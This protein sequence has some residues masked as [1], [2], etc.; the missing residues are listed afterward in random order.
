MHGSSS[1][2]TCHCLSYHLSECQ[3]PS[4]A[5]DEVNKPSTPV[6]LGN[7]QHSRFNNGFFV[8]TVAI[9]NL[10]LFLYYSLFT[11]STWVARTIEE[12][13]GHVQDT[14]GFGCS[15]DQSCGVT[16]DST[17]TAS[18]HAMAAAAALDTA[19]AGAL[20]C[21]QAAAD[22]RRRDGEA[23]VRGRALQV[24]LGYYGR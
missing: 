22:Q 18:I 2:D 24:R 11:K 9:D 1:D 20:D 21:R 16:F 12:G 13:S 8:I 17:V 6:V 5:T 10:P 7:K 14:G 15:F 19:V 4:V 23:G 3:P